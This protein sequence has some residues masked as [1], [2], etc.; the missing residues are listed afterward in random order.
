MYPACLRG[1]LTAGPDGLRGSDSKHC[2]ALLMRDDRAECP[3]PCACPREGGGPDHCAVAACCSLPGDRPEMVRPG[4]ADQPMIAAGRGWELCASSSSKLVMV[5]GL[6]EL[7]SLAHPFV[8]SDN[9]HPFVPTCLLAERRAQRQSR[10]PPRLRRH[11]RSR[12]AASP[13]FAR[14]GS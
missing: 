2:G 5:T 14:A 9:D 12:R 10:M 11:R 13:A 3:D 4:L 7:R 6:V 1:R 8:R